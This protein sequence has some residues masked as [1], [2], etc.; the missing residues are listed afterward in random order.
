MVRIPGTDRD[1]NRCQN[2]IDGLDFDLSD[3]HSYYER[4]E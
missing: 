2:D 4:F 1:L 3:I